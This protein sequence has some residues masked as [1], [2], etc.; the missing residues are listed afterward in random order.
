MTD[1]AH[2]V[3]L[4]EENAIA[5]FPIRR[6]RRFAHIEAY[7]QQLVTHPWWSARFPDAPL[8]IVLQRRSRSAT[9]SA[10]GCSGA[11]E[12][13]DATMVDRPGFIW[14]IDGHGWG[15]ETVLHE[16]AH[17]AAGPATGHGAEFRDALGEL[18]V[19]R[20]A[21]RPGP[22]FRT[23]SPRPGSPLSTTETP[24]RTTGSLGHGRTLDHRCGDGTVG[25]T[26]GALHPLTDPLG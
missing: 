11:G 12:W 1:A 14:L 10:A 20:R 22:R 18:G 25:D 23:G 13:I 6:F 7:V 24:G 26:R 4:A 19:T 5:A 17:L 2:Q 15:L 9:Y 16:F 8:E 3:I 21:S